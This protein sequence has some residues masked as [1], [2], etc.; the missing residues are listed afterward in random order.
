MCGING[1]FKYS[2]VSLEISRDLLENMNKVVNH[3]GPDDSGSWISGDGRIGMA[4][5]RLSIIDL[6]SAGHQPMVSSKGAVIVYNGEI[7]NF[8][9]IKKELDVEHYFSATDTEVLLYAYEKFGEDMLDKL[10][11]MFAFAIW[12]PLKK[13]LFLARDRIGIKPLYYTLQGGIFA[14][15]SEIR[16][17]LTLPWIRADLDEEALYHFLTFN[18]IYPPRTMFSGIHKFY[19][20]QMMM[21]DA[22]GVKIYKKYWDVS[23]SN[24]DDLS[25][26]E[27]ADIISRE[28]RASVTRRMIS[29]VPVGVFL[30]GGVDSSGITA[31]MNELTDIPVRTY[32]IGFE[33]APDFT[34]LEWA[35]RISNKFR[36]NHTEKIVTHD[37]IRTFLPTLVEIFDEPLADAT[38]IPIY[39]I[40]KLA[41]ES[42]TKVI[43]TGDGSD[44]IFLGYRNW[45][46]Y[47]KYKTLFDNFSRL[48]KFIKS[49]VSNSFG[50]VSPSSPL[51]ELLER[52]TQ[53]QQLFWGGASGFKEN[54]KQLLLTR[55]YREK[56]RHVSSETYLTD[57]WSLFKSLPKNGK[58]VDY[59]DWLCFYGLK[60]IVPNFYLHRADRIGMANSIELR[61][62]FLDHNVVNAALSIKSDFKIKYDEPKYV[63]KRAFEGI[64]DREILYRRKMG[65]CVPLKE[66]AGEIML[67]YLNEHAEAFCRETGLFDPIFMRTCLDSIRSG[68]QKFAFAVWNFYFLINWHKKWIT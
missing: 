47:I 67:D 19:P 55:H 50:L 44:E 65:F 61:V 63:L 15:A 30:S 9:D 49:L 41:R 27:S 62:P 37:D 38:S 54:T 35:R 3:R 66:W 17:L 60:A 24:Y 57:Y 34:E 68:S 29:D 22:S 4:H 36:T 21:V 59:V 13:S 1:I 12:D 23:Y 8:H 33:D 51:S 56:M 64:L 2:N 48:P 42:G 52:A 45:M 20:G 32:S 25:L 10:N 26:D 58:K 46:P 31:Y 7:Y 18:K 43:L 5:R 53:N 11:G 40:S 16:S 28:L 39:F 14:F 6:S